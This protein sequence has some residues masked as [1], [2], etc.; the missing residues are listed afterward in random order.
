MTNLGVLVVQLSGGRS[1]TIDLHRVTMREYRTIFSDDKQQ[2]DA[3]VIIAKACDL[4]LD[5]YLDL[6]QPDGRIVLDAF[7]SAAT[8]QLKDPNS[9]SASTSA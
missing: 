8:Q 4:S 9:A 3:D 1:L 7:F 6:P 2:V 5:D